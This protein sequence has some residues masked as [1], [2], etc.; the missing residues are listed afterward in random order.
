MSQGLIFI[1]TNKL[2]KNKTFF[3]LFV[4]WKPH[5]LPYNIYLFPISSSFIL[6]TFKCTSFCKAVLLKLGLS[7]EIII[8]CPSCK[9][10]GSMKHKNERM[11]IVTVKLQKAHKS[12]IHMVHMIVVYYFKSSEC[13][14]RKT[15]CTL[16]RFHLKSQPPLFKS[17][18]HVRTL[19]CL[20][21][22][23]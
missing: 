10:C 21:K 4:T 9:I 1:R 8:S 2:N 22:H 5:R 18:T 12:T 23:M 20:C 3:F 6:Y 11:V 19:V 16:R 17:G 14:M 13:F 15:D 7:N